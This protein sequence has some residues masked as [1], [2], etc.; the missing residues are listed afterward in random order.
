MAAPMHDESLGAAWRRG[1][2]EARSLGDEAAGIAG[3]IRTLL[4]SEVALAKA[5]VHEQISLAVKIA[6][7]GGVALVAGLLMATFAFI[8]L[9]VALDLVMPQWLAGLVTTAILAVIA[10][11]G[12][13]MARARL[14]AMTVVPK[15]TID[16][17]REDVRWAKDQLRSTTTS[18]ASGTP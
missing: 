17:V 18:S 7:W 13:L 2:D 14:K 16:S 3:D 5:E 6:I 12:A 1:K 11:V 8:T 10:A 4:Q 9:F 15:K